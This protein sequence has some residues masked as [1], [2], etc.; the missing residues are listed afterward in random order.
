MRK[1]I[2]EIVADPRAY[3]AGLK[4]AGAETKAFEAEFSKVTRGVLSG[5][6]AF[7]HLGRSIAFA[8]GGFVAFAGA[9]EFLKGSID[10]AREAGVAQRS[11]AAQM[12]ASGE[13]FDS[14][15][16]RVEKATLSL[17]KYG[18]TSEDSE[19]ALTILERGTGNITR[20]IGLQGV[21]ANLARAK[22]IDFASAATVV[23][24]VFGGQETALRRAVPGLAKHEHGLALIADAQKRLAGQAEAATTEAEKFHA[25]LHNT[26]VIVGT[27]L[28]PT[29]DRFLTKLG[30][31]LQKLNESGRLQRALNT[32]VRDA[33]TVLGH[34]KGLIE[35]VVSAL[36]GWHQALTILIGAWAGF[37]AAG[38]ASAVAVST[39][40]VVAAGITE[41]AW[42]AALISTGWGAL[43]VAA[44]IAATEV[45]AHWTAVKDW[46]VGF[47]HWLEIQAD[48]TMLTIVEPFSHLPW[49]LGKW[50]RDLKDQ[51]K[52][53]IADLTSMIVQGS[54][55]AANATKAQAAITPAAAPGVP[56]QTSTGATRPGVSASQR[57]RFDAMISRDLSRVQDI[58]TLQGQIARLQQIAGLIGK[59]LSA[60]KDITRRLTLEDQ[61]LAVQRQIRGDQATI[62]Q[63]MQDAAK[64]A[65][66]RAAQA[67][68]AMFDRLQFNVDKA[69]LT[70]TL[71]DDLKALQ[72]YKSV[73]E[74][75][76]ATQGSTLD[77]QKQLLGVETNIQSVQAQISQNR[78]DAADKAAQAAQQA[79]Q[80]AATRRDTLQFRLLGLGPTGGAIVPGVANLTKRLAGIREAVK[81]TFLDTTQTGQQLAHI[82]KILSG[83]FG[84][85]SETVRAAIDQMYQSIRDKLKSHTGDQTQFQHISSQKFVESLGLNLTGAQKRAIESRFA[86]VGAGGT[87]PGG[88]SGQFTGVV[89]SGDVHVHGVHDIKAFENEIAKRAKARPHTRR[90]A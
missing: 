36:G 78:K 56:T 45:I 38:I 62:S 29:L 83:Q 72:T 60:T 70:K 81:G 52:V 89:I 1:L 2:V 26:E 64:A 77:L 44:G 23:A 47:W 48:M 16:E 80:D 5:S 30:A 79:A 13:S 22:N 58:P 25:I 74:K 51:L 71:S 34:L 31:W 69:G 32:A 61:L 55:A 85:V 84:S 88:H 8:S 53:D 63:N 41:T 76:V 35:G 37:K 54:H 42:K 73:L 68:Q 4:K 50:A 67:Q 18:F 75:I 27:A 15:R 6:G 33:G 28:L 12:Q 87:V 40:N 11:L 19:K 24:K 82:G 17:E 21:A 90:G 86:T 9:T 14:N 66:D 10:A 20:A 46:F 43:A 49:G 39:A 65:A 7:E 59:R 57:Y 3:T